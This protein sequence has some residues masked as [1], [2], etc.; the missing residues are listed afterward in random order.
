MAERVLITGARAAA[1]LDIAR[2]FH[3]AGW[4]AHFAD[5][6]PA[7]IGRWSAAATGFHHY[8]SPVTDREGFRQRVSELTKMLD[9][10]LIVPACEEVFH[11][12]APALVDMFAGRLFAP[13]LGQL[14]RL[15]DKLEFARACAMWHL[16][17]PESQAIET[18]QDLGR[19]ASEAKEWVFKPRFSRFGESALIGP[20]RDALAALP[21]TPGQDWLAQRR[22]RGTE[23]SFYAV[24][25][26]GIL[27]AFSAYRSDWRMR[28]GASYAFEPLA[29]SLADEL[30]EL[31]VTLARKVGH[32]GQLAC[33]VM[34][35]ET[36]KPWLIE[37]NPRATSGVHLLA[38][39]GRLARAMIGT[40]APAVKQ[41]PAHLAPAMWLFG[42]P[43]AVGGRRIRNWWKALT[44]GHDVLA[45][46]GDRLPLIGALID[47][48]GFSLSG[49]KLGITMAAA[50]T[51]DIEWNGK[52]LS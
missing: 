9:V 38:G 4:E 48:L 45:R 3:A 21:V 34:I 49:K 31:A 2:D 47:S 12:A 32:S 42:L 37:C 29:S 28:G 5:C 23:A 14:R 24:A 43:I 19:F 44:N 17:V 50:T 36:T 22:I 27:T 15:H 46:P 11:L 26:Q 25:H 6:S 39:D 20:S 52:D 1:A 18:Q 16:P 41:Q 8:P 33:D 10:R 51:H 40:V 13:P 7:R 35:D 30:Y